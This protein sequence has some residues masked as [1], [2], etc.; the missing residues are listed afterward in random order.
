MLDFICS[1]RIKH[2][3][4]PEHPVFMKTIV[5]TDLAEKIAAYYGVRTINVLTGFKF[6]GE[7]I[8]LPENQENYIFGFEESFGFLSGSYV[9]D[10]DGVNAVMIICEMA[11]Y[12]TARGISL[13]DKLSEL[14]RKLRVQRRLQYICLAKPERKNAPFS[15]TALFRKTTCFNRK[16]DNASAENWA[17]GT[18]PLCLVISE[19]LNG[20][21][22]I[23]FYSLSL[24]R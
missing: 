10:K 22:T 7:Q 23:L 9:R 14:Y 6:I 11:A 18:E 15:K 13:E 4:M 8:G 1:Q 20:K 21:K 24:R 12:Y 19:G 5:T 17:R 2:K 16:P 3:A